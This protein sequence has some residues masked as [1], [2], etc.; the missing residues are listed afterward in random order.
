MIFSIGVEW[1]SKFEI[2]RENFLPPGPATLGARIG[3]GAW[4]D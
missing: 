3:R 2:F 4:G 1:S